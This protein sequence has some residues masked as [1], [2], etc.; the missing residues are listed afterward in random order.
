M[1]NMTR[2]L[3]RAFILLV[4]AAAV[5]AA[6]AQQTPPPSPCTTDEFRR[7]DFWIG[8]W[9]VTNVKG[10]TIGSSRITSVSRG[11]AV[12]EEWKDR[13]GGSGTSINFWEPAT[14]RWNQLWVGGAGGIL[15]LEGD[16]RD[17]AMELTGKTPRQTSSGSVL[18]RIRWT[19]AGDGSLQQL[20]LLSTDGGT[21]WR[22][23]FRGIYRRKQ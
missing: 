13:S 16:Y 8:E 3:L 7:F 6:G 17:G 22:E 9:V 2:L 15:R 4:V 21:S 1:T 12:L 19:A 5:P 20:W 14:S 11:C 18:D 10:D 23:S